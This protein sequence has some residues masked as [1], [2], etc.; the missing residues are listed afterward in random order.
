VLD[1]LSLDSSSP[2][3]DLLSLVSGSSLLG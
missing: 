2:V 3:L 1:L